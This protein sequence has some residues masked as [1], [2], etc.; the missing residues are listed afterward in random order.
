[1]PTGSALRR[2]ASLLLAAAVL[3]LAGPALAGQAAPHAPSATFGLGP[4]SAT[5]ADGRPAFNYVVS[6][7]SRLGDHVAVLNLSA[8]PQAFTAYVT[9]ASNDTDGSFTYP[10]P[11]AAPTDAGAWLHL[12]GVAA[13][14]SSIVVPARSTRILPL[15]VDVPATASPGDHAAAVVVSL[16]ATSRNKDGQR[17]TLDQ[18]VAVRAFFRVSGT[19]HPQLSVERLRASYGA[20]GLLTGTSTV[21]YRVHNTGNV[22]LSADQ[23]A[24]V[25]GLLTSKLVRGARVPVLLPGGSLDVT[26]PVRHTWAQLWASAKVTVTPLGIVGDSDPAT[27]PTT[28]SAHFLAVPW[29]LL[30]VVAGLLLLGG[31]RRRRR[32]RRPVPPPAAPTRQGAVSGT[33]SLLLVLAAGLCVLAV[34]ASARADDAV[35]YTDPAVTGSI[36]LC[37]VHGQNVL[38][39]KV[40][41]KP[42]VWLAVGTSAAAGDYA[43]SGRTAFLA[44]YQ[45]RKGITPGEWSGYELAAAS[46]YSNPAHPMSQATPLSAPLT[47]F[48][49]RYSPQWD[50]LVQLRLVL[51]G[52]GRPPRTA[53]Y[54]ATDIRVTGDTWRVVRGGTGP[55]SAGKATSTAALLRIPG[56]LGTPKP[57]AVASPPPVEGRPAPQV[58]GAHAAAGSAPQQQDQ[59]AATTPASSSAPL[60]GSLTLVGAVAIGALGLGVGLTLW[61][62]RRRSPA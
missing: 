18:R 46:V 32:G 2:T 59:A 57:G 27:P 60:G 43:R 50:G 3:A 6:P 49:G 14:T 53:A 8:Q 31:L 10:L 38:S 54:D 45:P 17:V 12:S 26:V 41:D 21:R 25:A 7:G 44:A 24:R 33:A 15:A 1:M 40:T 48:L 22:K 34:P 61:A 55:C 58:V 20:T 13:R 39:G 37:D 30:A 19:L 28:A 36:G 42:F 5:K 16:K 51:G 62:V 11:S 23:S 29:L 9:D 4:A 35:P 52:S 47:D 56:A